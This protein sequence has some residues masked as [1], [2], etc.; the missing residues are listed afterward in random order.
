[1]FYVKSHSK[2]HLV[3]LEKVLLHRYIQVCA[4]NSLD[5]TSHSLQYYKT[6]ANDAK[7]STSDRKTTQMMRMFVH[8]AIKE[9][10]KR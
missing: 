5:V 7:A 1:M 6:S 3:Y 10:K 4:L 2:S 8:K 9:D